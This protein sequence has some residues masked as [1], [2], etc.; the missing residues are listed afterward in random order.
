MQHHLS[1][2]SLTLSLAAETTTIAPSPPTS[3]VSHLSA[4]GPVSP[5]PSPPPPARHSLP[6]LL[7]SSPSPTRALTA[8]RS[9]TS[10]HCT[11]TTSSPPKPPLLSRDASSSTASS[12]AAPR[13]HP[14]ASSTP[15]TLPPQRSPQLVCLPSFPLSSPQALQQTYL[16]CPQAFLPLPQV[17]PQRLSPSQQARR[18]SPREKRLSPLTLRFQLLRLA[19]AHPGSLVCPPPSEQ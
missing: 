13:S 18:R 6:A 1:V 4:P 15:T 17:V 10:R 19:Q 7:A 14:S 12:A 9:A 3:L 5:S 16:A 8:R 2:T 11:S